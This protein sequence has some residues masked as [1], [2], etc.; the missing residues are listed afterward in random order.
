MNS[1]PS[2]FMHNSNN[3]MSRKFEEEKKMDNGLK[4]LERVVL[5]LE[6]K[7]TDRVPVC[8]LSVGC[9]RLALGI[10]FPDFSTNGELAAEALIYANRLTGEDIIFS[11]IDLSVEAA[12]FGQEMVYPPNTTAHPNYHNPLIK[13]VDDYERLNVVD[14][15]SSPRMSNYLKMTCLLVEKSGKDY[16]VISFVYGPLGVLGMMRGTERMY[17]DILEYPEKVKVALDVINE[18]LKKI[19]SSPV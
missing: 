11:F 5:T 14:P 17:E 15:T 12:D 19:Y 4:P 3:N 13:T 18:V 1:F 16:P 6:G 2:A 10:S 9:A 8:T 7:E